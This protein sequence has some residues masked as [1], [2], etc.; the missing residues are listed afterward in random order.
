MKAY[1]VREDN[2]LKNYII[3]LHEDFFELYPAVRVPRSYG[4]LAAHVI[5]FSYPDYIRYCATHGGTIRKRGTFLYPVFKSK[6]DAEKICAIINTCW[7]NYC[8]G[9]NAKGLGKLIYGGE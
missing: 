9:M 8:T 3:G 5:G 4:I 1:V 7:T 2:D 6:T